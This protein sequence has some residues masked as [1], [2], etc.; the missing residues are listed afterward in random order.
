MASF[1]VGPVVAALG[2][3][4]QLPCA[5][6][7]GIQPDNAG[8]DDVWMLVKRRRLNVVTEAAPALADVGLGAGENARRRGC[9]IGLVLGGDQHD[10]GQRA[11]RQAACD[12]LRR[13]FAGR[14]L[15]EMGDADDSG[16]GRLGEIN[17]GLQSLAE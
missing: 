2:F 16:F 11:E 7:D 17:Y 9:V 15:G 6:F 14:P 1:E 12:F 4:Q 5:A 8:G 3:G 10:A 13:V